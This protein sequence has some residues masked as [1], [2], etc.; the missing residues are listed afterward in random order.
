MKKRSTFISTD[1]QD[2]SPRTPGDE[3]IKENIHDY[4]YHIKQ[5]NPLSSHR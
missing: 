5:L 2:P 4:K 1:M 3:E